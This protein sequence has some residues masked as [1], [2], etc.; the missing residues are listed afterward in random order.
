MP[1]VVPAVTVRPLVL[2]ATAGPGRD[3]AGRRRHGAPARQPDHV[4]R[5][6]SNSVWSAAAKKLGRN[7]GVWSVPRTWSRPL[8]SPQARCRHARY[9]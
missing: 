7:S 5:A 4:V 6:G 2:P 3:A 1:P 8:R 9:W